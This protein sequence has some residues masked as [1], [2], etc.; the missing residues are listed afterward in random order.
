[1]GKLPGVGC[2]CNTR[3]SFFLLVIQSACMH[4]LIF[5]AIWVNTSLFLVQTFLP[6][7]WLFPMSSPGR[8]V[9]FMPFTWGNGPTNDYLGEEASMKMWNN[10]IIFH[11]EWMVLIEKHKIKLLPKWASSGSFCS[12][13][14]TKMWKVIYRKIKD[15]EVQNFT[16]WLI[17]K[18]EPIHH[19]EMVNGGCLRLKGSTSWLR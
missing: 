16:N 3:A 1:M 9:S 6:F 2:Q 15:F 11:R 10:I 19:P 7:I 12:L 17:S 14:K 13:W 5:Q 4:K 8:F 18:F